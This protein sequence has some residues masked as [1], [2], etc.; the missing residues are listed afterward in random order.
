[1]KYTEQQYLDI[2]MF[3]GDEG[4]LALHTKKLVKV[5]KQHECWF[6]LNDYSETPNHLINI[7]D[8]A[9]SEKALVDGDFWG[10]YYMCLSCLNKEIELYG[11]EL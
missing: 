6:G 10:K 1:M 9:V 5:R 11:E 8:T 2:D 7:G 3:E 4:T